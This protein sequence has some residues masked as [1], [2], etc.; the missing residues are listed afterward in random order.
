MGDPLLAEADIDRLTSPTPTG[1]SLTAPCTGS[2]NAPAGRRTQAALAGS[3]PIIPI[4][5]SRPCR[6]Q[7]QALRAASGQR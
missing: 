3:K 5:G 2:G 1:S 6:S 4:P 7:G